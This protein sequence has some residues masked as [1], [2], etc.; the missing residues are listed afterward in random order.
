M[1]RNIPSGA[2][3]VLALLVLAFPALA[4]RQ[5]GAGTNR[6]L[7]RPAPPARQQRDERAQVYSQARRIDINNINMFVTNYGTFAND[8]ENQGNSGLFFPKGTL[9]TA[10][11]Q[12]GIW[13]GGKV[14]GQPRVAIAEYS[15]EFSPGPMDG[16]LPS[17]ASNPDFVVYKVS[18]FTGNPE[19][20]AHVERDAADLARDRTLDPVVHHSWSEYLNGAV[21]YGAPT[22]LWSLPDPNN[23]SGTVSVLGPDVSGDQMLWSVYNDADP[24]VHTNRSGQS[25][26]L[27]IEV[28]QKTFA[29]DRQGALGNTVFLEYTLANKGGN[30]IDSCYIMFWSDPDLG[31]ASDDLVGCDTTLSLGY[32][33][34]A[35]NLD[36]AY[37]DRPPALGYDFFKGPVVAGDTLGLTSFIYYINGTDPANATQTFNYMRGFTRDGE[38]VIDPTTSEQTRFYYP[39][40]PVAGTGWL[41]SNPSDRR[42][43]MITGPF[44]L[45]AGQTQTIVGAIVVAQG[46]DRLSSVTGLKFFDVNAQKAFD[47]DF[48][49]PSPPPAPRITYST[50]HSRVNLMWDS[51][52]RF[53]YSPAPG[54]AFEGYNIYQGASI[55]GP[56]KRLKTFDLDNGI[57]DVREP[58]FDPNTGLII[59]DTPTAFGLDNGVAYSYSTGADAVRGG[60]LKDGSTYYY[61]VTAYAVNPTP[62]A[63]L[64]KVLETS[65]QPVVVTVQRPPLGTDL[66]AARVDAA[67]VHRS[68]TAVAPT[69]DHVIVDIV[70]PASITGHT[71]AITY[72]DGSARPGLVSTTPWN[73]VDLTTGETLLSNQTERTDS[74]AYA[75]VDGMLVKLRET[76]AGSAPLN[77]VFYSP[78]RQQ[79]PF[80]GVGAGLGTFEDS[81]GYAWDFFAGIDYTVQPELFLPV[82]LRFGATQKAYRFFR[83]QK[84]DGSAPANTGR[85]YTY[86]GFQTAPFTAW[87]IS[88]NTQLEV[89]FVEKRITDD[90]G[91]QTGEQPETHDG[92]WAPGTDD[93]GGREYLF[94]SRRPYTGTENPALAQDQAV[95]G[96]DTLWMYAA[97]LKSTG[98][99]TQAGDRF[100]VTL[101]DQP[102]TSNDT[103]VFTTQAPARGVTALQQDGLNRIRAVP[104]PYYA[105]STYELSPFNRIVKFMNMPGQA[106]V[107][108]FNLSGQLVRTIK[109]TD[110]T[111]SIVEWDLENENRLPVASG[112]Y[113]FHI[114]VPGAGSTTGRLVVFM[115]K[116]RLLT[117]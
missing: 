106:T 23:P 21:P 111:S 90:D 30:D 102:G 53:N 105:R 99:A 92:V 14:G 93:L 57:T 78:F 54:Y 3:A 66:G 56:W 116:E 36:Q 1:K 110:E 83:D 7:R 4:E 87:D 9:K 10:V 40:D 24:S 115:E 81:F 69:S 88:T 80:A 16:A 29:F 39:G 74:P 61:A 12:S 117:F 91:V 107:R 112:V 8:I 17:D 48:Q 26:P 50:D 19:D 41:D 15:Q 73:L 25:L 67:S 35:T 13:I 31:G 11:Y 60:S 42:F 114:E 82:E 96:A 27:G 72:A 38:P 86:G 18:R 20:T 47:I 33:Y 58:V 45:P 100:H 59:N 85:G 97:W 62:P 64:E 77:D 70:D 75:P 49:L 34:N 32:V 103:L 113:V 68:S 94:I 28:K 5:V 84:A 104:N 46:G 71:Y 76:Q 37:G 52:S 2:W 22:R 6:V 55:S 98:V 63:G 101:G 79:A 89:A 44:Q 95:L 51:G 65:F 109:K 108:I 43:M